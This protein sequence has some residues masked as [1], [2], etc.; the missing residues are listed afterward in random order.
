MPDCGDLNV[1]KPPEFDASKVPAGVNLPA[2]MSVDDL[3]KKS[4]NPG[5]SDKLK[6]AGTAI[7]ANIKKTAN[8]L[9][10]SAIAD[11]VS[12]AVSTMVGDIKAGIGHMADGL[13]SLK[14]KIAGFNPADKLKGLSPSS[15][16]GAFESMKNKAK[17]QVDGLGGRF[18]GMELDCEKAGLGAAGKVNTLAQGSGAAALS[19]ISNK[20]RIQMAKDPEF[21]SA[22]ID[23]A[24]QTA[25]QDTEAK[26]TESATGDDKAEKSVQEILHSE[27]LP[28]RPG[29]DPGDGV[30][31]NIKE[32]YLMHAVWMVY[33]SF[34]VIPAGYMCSYHFR[35]PTGVM[36]G[37]SDKEE[38]ANTLET[39]RI[40]ALVRALGCVMRALRGQYDLICGDPP[41]AK[42]DIFNARRK[43]PYTYHEFLMNT[44]Y[45]PYSHGESHRIPGSVYAAMNTPWK[46]IH[47]RKFQQMYWEFWTDVDSY[48][49]KYLTTT[50][51][52]TKTMSDPVQTG[53]SSDAFWVHHNQPASV[54][55]AHT[56][57]S[58]ALKGKTPMN[59]FQ[60]ALQDSD[61][62]EELHKNI[63]SQKEQYVTRYGTETNLNEDNSII[64]ADVF[65][66]QAPAYRKVFDTRFL[67]AIH[68]NYSTYN[69][70]KLEYLGD[71]RYLKEYIK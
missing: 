16:K 33:K 46:V 32:A 2:G 22:K 35:K 42:E 55:Y 61:I 19:S 51:D 67:I 43:A 28:E 53:K 27:T 4:E 15:P 56:Q 57:V 65:I 44:A 39:I 17:S 6:N 71:N 50:G 36:F 47:G 59:N 48:V 13:T 26:V 68:F 45:F 24:T 62:L 1:P 37:L 38:A 70:D 40:A 63:K 11:R 20:D 34:Q 18:K 8:Q 5:L 25:V 23:E 30:G 69:I 49:D 64:V 10:P 14:D 54:P 52:L 31:I 21:K 3:K 60:N 66:P 29:V 9:N 58:K 7:G 12:G 41:P